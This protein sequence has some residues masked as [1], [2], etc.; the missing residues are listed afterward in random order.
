MVDEVLKEAGLTLQDLD[1]LAFGRGL[2]A[3]LVFVSVL[4]SLKA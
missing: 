1:A 2:V 4:A 3:L